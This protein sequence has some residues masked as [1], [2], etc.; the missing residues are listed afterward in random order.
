LCVREEENHV[1]N[2]DGQLFIQVDLQIFTPHLEV[3]A[4]RDF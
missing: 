4:L 1:L 2:F 3:V